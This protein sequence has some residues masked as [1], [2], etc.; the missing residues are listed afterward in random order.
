MARRFLIVLS[1]VLAGMLAFAVADA[2]P[3]RTADALVAVVD[4][5]IDPAAGLSLA[6]GVDLVAGGTR[7]ADPYGHGTAVATEVA[8]ACGGCTILPVRVLSSAGTAPWTRVATGIVW[9]VDHGA[10]VVN[11]SVAG[12]GGSPELRR[13]VRYALDHDVLLVAAAG[14][15]ADATPSYPAAYPGVVA[16]AARAA[17]GRLYDWS[18]RGA[19]VDLT[20][21]GCAAL[22]ETVC[23]TSFAA[24]LVAALAARERAHDPSAS[25]AAIAARLPRLVAGHAGRTAPVL[26]VSGSARPGSVLRAAASA[27]PAGAHV[28]WFRCAPAGGVHDCVPAST[29]ASYRVR[30]ADAGS[31]LVARVVTGSFA[32]LWLAASPRLAV[33]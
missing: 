31:A 1:A 19:W 17:D 23:G 7:P 22:P 8:R 29:G 16:V 12:P 14:N 32:G 30:A 27:V 5:G 33:S 3:G 21:P 6:Q 20:A 13:A 26:T 9:A 15:A 25:A 10:R 2:S 24:P 28:G 11:V 18:S 4:S